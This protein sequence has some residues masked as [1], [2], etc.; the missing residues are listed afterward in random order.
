MISLLTGTAVEKMVDKFKNTIDFNTTS[1]FLDNDMSSIMTEEDPRVAEY[2]VAVV[3][4]L[5]LLVGIF[6]VNQYYQ[7]IIL[8][9]IEN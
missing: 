7:A 3:T 6:Q 1:Q 5:T 9:K 8:F 4:S 2:R